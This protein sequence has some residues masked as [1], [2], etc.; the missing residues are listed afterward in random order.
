MTAEP[1]GDTHTR[2][3]PPE[4]LADRR[5]ELAGPFAGGGNDGAGRGSPKPPVG[6]NRPL[7]GD[8]EIVHS[9][10]PAQAH[11]GQARRVPMLT[12]KRPGSASSSHPAWRYPVTGVSVPSE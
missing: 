12:W 1:F 2:E 7:P 8:I 11:S 3:M 10:E 5:E 4:H 6:R 9:G